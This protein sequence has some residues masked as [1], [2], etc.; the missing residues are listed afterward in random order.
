MLDTNDKKKFDEM[1]L[2][3][4]NEAEYD[5]PQIFWSGGE[6]MAAF[7]KGVTVKYLPPLTNMKGLQPWRIV[8]RFEMFGAAEHGHCKML[9]FNTHQPA[10][11][12]RPFGSNMRINFCKAIINDA[13]QLHVNDTT[14]CGWVFGGDAN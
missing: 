3:A 12:G 4:F 13:L 8:E 6:K 14:K 1:M 10:S 5:E 11:D 9:V 7:R 2:D